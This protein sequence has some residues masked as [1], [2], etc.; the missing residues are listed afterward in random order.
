MKSFFRKSLIMLAIAGLVGVNIPVSAIATNTTSIQEYRWDEHIEE[1][2]GGDYVEGEVVVGIDSS[3][4]SLT[5]TRLFGG[6]ELSDTGDAITT[7]SEDSLELSS[8]ESANKDIS[9]EIIRRDDMTTREI[10]EAL[11]GDSAVVFAEP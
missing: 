1:L 10:M 7:V 2:L 8:N 9:I 4:K 11:R 3:K 6:Q 5:F